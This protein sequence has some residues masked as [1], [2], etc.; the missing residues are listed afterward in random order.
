MSTQVNSSL[1]I[2]VKSGRAI[3][4]VL[5]GTHTSARVL[6]SATLPLS[7]PC[8]P[9]MQQPYHAGFGRLE[10]NRTVLRRRIA[11]IGRA[12]TASVGG[13]LREAGTSGT[14]ISGAALIVGSTI[15]PE[16]IANPHIRAHALEGLL[17]RTVVAEAL[18]AAG[19]KAHVIVQ[20]D[21]FAAAAALIGRSEADLKRVLNELGRG[22][23][24]S[25]RADEK[26]A[27][28]GAWMMLVRR[29]SPPDT[30]RTRA[31]EIARRTRG[32]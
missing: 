28:L 15:D 20:R 29:P 6:R 32:A 25:W 27:A 24:G 16:T 7:D 26:L 12:A 8:D 1:G 4:V 18:A 14:R 23:D 9:E 21:A 30:R 3:A 13:L 10:T 19:L 31:P 11:R 5:A 17:F 2:R 22:I